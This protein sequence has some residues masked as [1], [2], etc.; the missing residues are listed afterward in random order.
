M[1]VCVCVC[2]CV[3][4]EHMVI[5]FSVFESI[6]GQI[7]CL[8]P[9]VVIVNFDALVFYGELELKLLHSTQ[10]LSCGFVN[11]TILLVET[12]ILT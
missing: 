5:N 4:T 6:I 8:V 9:L 1:C 12:Y 11:K 2:V 10:T 3:C 7:D